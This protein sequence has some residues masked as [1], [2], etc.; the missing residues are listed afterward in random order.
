MKRYLYVMILSFWSAFSFLGYGQNIVYP[1]RATTA[2]VKSGTSFEIW[3]NALPDQTVDNVVLKAPYQSCAT[4]ITTEKGNW[5][6]DNMSGKSYNTKIVVTVPT[7]TPADRYDIVL[8]TSKGEVISYGGVKVV[9]NFLN[10]Y[11][12]M[13]LSDGHLYQNGYNTDVL[14]KRKSAMLDI[15]NIMDVQVLIETGDNMYNVRNHP[16][17]E[18]YYFLGN[19]TLNT[20]GMSKTTAATFLIP[21]DHEGLNANDFAQGTALQNAT[22]VNDY[23]GLQN[24]NF[25]YGNGRFMLLNNAWVVSETNAGEHQY[26]IDKAI[27]WLKTNGKGGNFHL[28][29]G[30]AYNKMHHNID[31]F[32]KLSLV[33]AGDKHNIF[34]NNPYSFTPGSAAIAYIA[35]AIRDHFSFNLFKVNNSN[36][37]YTTPSGTNA[38]NTV[39]FAGTK[40]NP[41]SWESNLTIAFSTPNDGSSD[42]NKATLVNRFNFPI[43]NAKI[44]FVVPK[45]KTYS[46]TNGQIDQ[47]FE[48]TQFHII[49]VIKDLEPNSTTEVYIAPGLGIDLCPN[50]PNKSA[51]GTCGCGVPE[52]SCTIPVT[53]IA[54]NPVSCNLHLNVTQPLIASITPN[55]ATNKSLT[56]SSSNPTIASVNAQGLVTG[57]SGGIATIEA[58][59]A[60]GTKKASSTLTVIP[61][62]TVYQA[63]DVEYKGPALVTNQPDYH[64]TGFLDF[65]NASNDFIK[66]TVYAPAEGNYDVAF[67]YA[68]SS[69]R[70][71]KLTLN[72]VDVQSSVAF[73]STGS[74]SVWN[75]YTI[76][77][78]LIAGNN[79]IQLTATGA[80]GGNFDELVLSK[81]LGNKA[82]SSPKNNRSVVIYPNP[83]Q[84]SKIKIDFIG[85]ENDKKTTI[86]V[87]ALNGQIMYEETQQSPTQITLPHSDKLEEGLYLISVKSETVHIIKKLIIQH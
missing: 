45:G 48:G 6:Y 11:Y 69:I 51:P 53:N 21:G 24:F 80:S 23:Y 59:T 33:L 13:H 18:E 65:T 14:L 61:S 19:T 83:S 56:W 35:A 42:T 8:A 43:T 54:I 16:E 73:P 15:A 30:H 44:R 63:E 28:T 5:I 71:L 81:T 79:S 40:D 41:A 32:Q 52:G 29:A 50:D 67:R 77:L 20:K 3:F 70:A 74:F 76:N 62:N 12:V 49:D 25:Q 64:G 87:V 84:H 22:F 47:E 31:A 46:A 9:K 39:L 75:T 57:L 1:W 10:E 58:I 72:E 37:S 34:T 78:P 85:F 27:D 26:Q 38:S 4:T 66:W 82:F 36:G 55:N 2:I 68:A 60:D 7:S 17:R 86:Q